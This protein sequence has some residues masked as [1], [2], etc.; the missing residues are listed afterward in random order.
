MAN[1]H[2]LAEDPFSPEAERLLEQALQL[3]K[4][5]RHRLAEALVDSLESATPDEIAAAWEE[6]ALR[7]IAE[8]D[9]GRMDTVPWSEVKQRLY[10]GLL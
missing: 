10:R 9:A 5:E 8:V 1:A 2:A 3:K 6:E 4:D 7:R